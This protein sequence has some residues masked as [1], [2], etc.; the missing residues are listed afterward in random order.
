GSTPPPARR[1]DPARGTR[2]P[3]CAHTRSRSCYGPRQTARLQAR[4]RIGS[5]S[6]R[7]NCCGKSASI[8]CRSGLPG[9]VAAQPVLALR[10]PDLVD[11]VAGLECRHAFRQYH[12]RQLAAR[13]NVDVRVDRLGP[14]ERPGTHEQAVAGHDV[15][16][17]PQRRA[18][19]PAKEHIMVMP[20]AAA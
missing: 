18:A 15:V 2:R 1:L 19:S 7:L 9:T 11:L 6:P 4:L 16:A 13:I 17:A 5:R 3:P 8:P 10:R 20:A 14:V 12:P